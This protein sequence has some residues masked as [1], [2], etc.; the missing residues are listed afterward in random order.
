MTNKRKVKRFKRMQNAN[1]LRKSRKKRFFKSCK[2]IFRL[3]APKI[4][5]SASVISLVTFSRSVKDLKLAE[6]LIKGH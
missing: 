6:E 5:L 4:L 3:Y 1:L 2:R